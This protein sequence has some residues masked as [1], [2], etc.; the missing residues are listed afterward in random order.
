LADLK[1]REYTTA[2]MDV[3]VGLEFETAT[4]VLKN[5]LGLATNARFEIDDN[6]RVIVVDHGERVPLS[7]LS[8]GYQSVLG[9]AVDI[10]DVLTRV[11]PNLLVAEGIVLLDEIGAHLHPTW[12]M[13]IVKSLRQAVPAVQFVTSTHDPL[14]LRGLGAGEVVVMERDENHRIQTVADLPSP[15]DLRVDQ[16]LTSDFFGMNTTVDPEA[17]HLF[18]EYYAL[19]ALPKRTRKQATELAELKEQLKDR[20]YLGTNPRETLMYEAIDELV[21]KYKRSTTTR[22]LDLKPEAVEAIA[23]AWA[24]APLTRS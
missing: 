6:R 2:S 20:Q 18:D 13:R 10:L 11:F 1:D 15:D 4:A 8:D 12:K 24:D 17:E 14:C 16:I 9:T 22:I 19:L 23:K 5:L 3:V 21:A 7:Q